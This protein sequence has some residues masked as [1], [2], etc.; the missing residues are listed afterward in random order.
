MSRAI[1]EA[2]TTLPRRGVD[3]RNRQGHGHLAAVLAAP[4]RFEV[5]DSDALAQLSKDFVFFTPSFFGDDGADRSADHFVRAIS[6]HAFGAPIPRADVLCRSLLTM[7]SSDVSTMAASSRASRSCDSRSV[8]EPSAFAWYPGTPGRRRRC[9]PKGEWA[10]Q[11][12]QSESACHLSSRGACD[13]RGS[14]P[15]LPEAP[16]ELGSRRRIAE[17][18]G[19]RTNTSSTGLPTASAD[20]QPVRRSATS[21]T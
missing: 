3:W 18:S 4:Y 1:F 13:H 21:F 20:G 5:I 6:E 16:P 11:C 10:P 19:T 9:D 7:A 12:H 8:F 14:P 15:C 17:C 2:P